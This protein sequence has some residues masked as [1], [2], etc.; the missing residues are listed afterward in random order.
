[1]DASIVVHPI[2][3]Q[4]TGVVGKQVHS[5]LLT[6]AG[7]TALPGVKKTAI[8]PDNK[9]VNKFAMVAL[10]IV[11][12]KKV[13]RGSYGDG[14]CSTVLTVKAVDKDPITRSPVM[15]LTKHHVSSA[16]GEVAMK[17]GCELGAEVEVSGIVVGYDAENFMWET[18]VYAMTVCGAAVQDAPRGR[19]DTVPKTLGYLRQWQGSPASKLHQAP[20]EIRRKQIAE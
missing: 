3:V 19:M 2:Q 16:L 15:W 10:G 5:R 1:M 4:Y 13:I 20:Y 7:F 14:I 12:D 11:V 18:N 17:Q 9:D 8:D 6:D